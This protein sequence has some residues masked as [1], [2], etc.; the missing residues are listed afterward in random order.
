[1]ISL[2]QRLKE[3]GR[4]ARHLRSRSQWEE[5]LAEEM[6]L[7][8]ELR[9]AE[10][11]D[12][13]AGEAQAAAR[14]RFGNLS[15]LREDS[16]AAWGWTFWESLAQD[17][18]YG[19]R[20]LLA[21][22]GF[23]AV[24]LLS[25]GLGIGANTAIFCIVNA[26]MLRTLPVEDP[27]RLVEVGF[28]STGFL[29][30]PLWEQIRDHQH[31]FSGTLAYSP[32]TLDLSSGGERKPAQVLWV[33]GD[34]FH[35]LGVPAL[36]GRLIGRSDDVRGG[37]P[38]GPVAVISYAFW[39]SHFAGDPDVLG[40]T[41]R[42]DRHTFTVVGVT[43]PWFR[44]LDL[45]QG[46]SV[47]IPIGCEPLLHT[48][49]SA[50]DERGWWWMRALG[51]LKPGESLAEAQARMKAI[52]PE[53]ARATLPPHWHPDEAK[54]YLS[55]KLQLTPAATGFSST[56]DQ[57]R[58]ALFVVLGLVNIVLLIACANV[59]NLLLA[60]ATARRRE[61][62]IR[63][64]IGAGKWR[65]IRQ[66]LTESL[67]LAGGGALLGLV[68]SIWGSKYLVQLLST[69][70]NILELDIS[71]DFRVFAF[72]AAVA[73][74]TALLFG[75]A[76]ALRAAQADPNE[77]LKTDARGAVPGGSKFTLSKALVSVQVALSLVL[78]VGA[79]LFLQ[80]FRK[81]LRVDP[82]FNKEHVLLVRTSV[83][84]AQVP[85]KARAA[86]FNSILERSR[87][88]PGVL[89]AAASW[90]TPISHYFWD[91]RTYPE[92]W[93]GTPHGE[94][95]VLYI[96]VVSPGYFRTLETPILA[97][98]DFSSR[99]TPGSQRVIIVSESAAH[100]FWPR[101]DPIGKLIGMDHEGSATQHDEYRVM[102]VVK[103]TK[104][105]DLDEAAHRTAYLPFSQNEKPG[106]D[107]AYEIRSG[108]PSNTLVPQLRRAIARVN[109]EI[110]LEFQSL[111][112]QIN[113]SLLQPRVVAL[114]SSGFGLSA[115][116]LAAVGLYGVMSYTVARRRN[117]IGIRIALGAEA[118]SVVWLVLRDVLV[119]FGIGLVA[120]LLA[121]TAAARL[122][123]SM[124]F[125]VGTNDPATLIASAVV[126]GSAA[127][128]A[129]F[130]PAR[131]AA[132]LDP[133]TALRDE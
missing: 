62:S 126:L 121:S 129:G 51:R 111:D 113:D 79:G 45:D 36:R 78:V 63:L 1:M 85:V 61:M 48:D 124:L 96:N 47:A 97:G 17:V 15:R 56:R 31:A 38:A 80:S 13:P 127:L 11:R 42:L 122:A 101:A 3:L 70:K 68:F 91:E 93:R 98:R 131:R 60:R 77:S 29:T 16:R 81:L 49:K 72:N 5:D 9:A 24:A 95:T 105:G 53:I 14:K 22:P 4:R 21:G 103:D 76:P 92:E 44:G 32:T 8:L 67:L 118:H 104:Y 52:S 34:F 27:Q 40:K 94:D 82:G 25:L 102:G 41:V 18:R 88:I 107:M 12:A 46:Y 58:T 116:L 133:M 10:N 54:D 65:L 115:L 57:Y 6:R 83:P 43:P 90:R 114:L 84:P 109:G 132:R 37:G 73:I 39:K 19:C 75:I 50:L 125:G 120:G 112:S 59:A 108:L 33:S 2:K 71:P 20:S 89:S 119:M 23:A 74:V 35:V 106:A 117:E 100:H 28:G 64:A 26:V 66:L 69:S 110:S 123:S 99:D 7:H 55:R 87:G 128:I 130:L 86:M 30:N